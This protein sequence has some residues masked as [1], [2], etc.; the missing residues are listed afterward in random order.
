MTSRTRWVL[1]TAVIVLVAAILVSL[2]A[3]GVGFH[4]SPRVMFEVFRIS[5]VFSL[6]I[7]TSL[8]LFVPLV[9]RSIFER[10]AAPWNWVVLATAMAPITIAGCALASFV[11]VMLGYL[12][13]PFLAVFATGTRIGLVMTVTFG[14]IVSAYESMRG[15][16]ER[17]NRALAAKAQDEAAAQRAAAAARQVA[18]EARLAA[19]E[20]RVQPHFLFNTLNSIASLIPS[21]P[22]GAERMTTQLAA[23]L[24]SSLA[25]EAAPFVA[26]ADEL[27]IIRQYLEIEGVRLGS[28]LRFGIEA[29]H[30]LQGVL[31]PRLSLQTIVENSVKYAV[32][33]RREGG[34]IRVTARQRGDRLQL[35]VEDDGPG[36]EL[37]DLPPGH[38][39]SL[40]RTRIELLYEAAG[41]LTV[42]GAAG[43]CIVNIDVPIRHGEP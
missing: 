20:S 15:D 37:A 5:F 6:S 8:M 7:G 27:A 43:R 4:T 9:Q 21:D 19:L 31:V 24:R 10:L 25:V 29:A 18:A 23:L 17:K 3:G 14:L 30:A 40:L 1:R 13:G 36:F 2:T 33:P 11:L 22:S 28:R 39:L 42:D 34:T 26:L 41:V 12:P 35:T 16:L 38:G 32:A